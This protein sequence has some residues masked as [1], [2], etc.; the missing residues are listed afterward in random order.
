MKQFKILGANVT[1][2][3]SSG[4]TISQRIAANA[5]LLVGIGANTRVLTASQVMECPLSQQGSGYCGMELF[6]KDN[7]SVV[8]LSAKGKLG[9]TN[10]QS[11]GRIELR[12]IEL[13]LYNGAFTRSIDLNDA[14]E[15]GVQSA[16]V[17]DTADNFTSGKLKIM[18]SGKLPN[19]NALSMDARHA[20]DTNL[21]TIFGAP[22]LSGHAEIV[23]DFEVI[24]V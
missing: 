23:V 11:P 6:D 4:F 24:E 9:K 20:G 17:S 3:A 12:T 14:A 18:Y 16:V 19:T 15:V 10:P 13:A 21:G 8:E 2:T 5:E 1:F 22:G 7:N